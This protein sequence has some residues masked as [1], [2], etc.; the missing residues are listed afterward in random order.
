MAAKYPSI[1]ADLKAAGLTALQHDAYRVAL[2][3]LIAAAF[4]ID[5]EN[6]QPHPDASG[7]WVDSTSLATFGAASVSIAGT[8]VQGRNLEFRRTHRDE[9]RGFYNVN[10]WYTP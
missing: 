7:N 9:F 2:V 1:A 3:S 8:S 4:A 6:A 10:M 5:P